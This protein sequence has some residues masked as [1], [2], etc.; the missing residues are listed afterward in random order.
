[1]SI[2]HIA[3]VDG[4]GV[5]HPARLKNITG[6]GQAPWPLLRGGWLLKRYGV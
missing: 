4:S 6:M 1:M 2:H 5:I 3:M